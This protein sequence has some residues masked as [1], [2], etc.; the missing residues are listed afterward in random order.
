MAEFQEVIRQFDRLCKAH[1]MCNDCSLYEPNGADRC[2]ISALINDSERIERE[3]MK[4]AAEH[5]EPV[6]PTWGDWFVSKG[7][8]PDKWD[9]LTSAYMNIGCVPKLLHS[10]I[11]TNIAKKLGLESKEG[12]KN[13]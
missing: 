3:I 7:M 4:W 5:P 11:P 6:Y 8:L 12:N 10:P 13:G 9:N 1:A 2:G